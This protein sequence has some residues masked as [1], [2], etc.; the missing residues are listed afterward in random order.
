MY[1]IATKTMSSGEV[2]LR[3][4]QHLM[5]EPLVSVGEPSAVTVARWLLTETELGNKSRPPDK[6]I[7][8][9]LC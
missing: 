9:H 3:A 5:N 4:I 1:G 6:S 7:V 8:T 2:V